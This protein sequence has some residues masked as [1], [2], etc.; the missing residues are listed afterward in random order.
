MMLK[1]PQTDEL[2]LYLGNFVPKE[3]TL[4]VGDAERI[5][6]RIDRV[7][8]DLPIGEHLLLCVWLSGLRRTMRQL[9]D[10]CSVQQ[11]S[12]GVVTGTNGSSATMIPN[13]F[14][15]AGFNQ[16]TWTGAWG[17]VSSWNALVAVLEMHGVGTFFDPRLDN[18]GQFPVVARNRFGHVRVSPDDD[19]V[20]SKLPALHFYQLSLAAP[21]R[22]LS[23]DGG[24]RTHNS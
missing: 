24:P 8:A 22:V 16:H 18:A 3:S 9:A 17:T 15:L 23:G 7:V 10:L 19:R 11:V 4:R 21:K 6:S 2:M 20:T 12:H 5:D 1:M 13:A 14:G